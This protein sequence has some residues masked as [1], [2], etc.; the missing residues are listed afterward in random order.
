MNWVVQNGLHGLRTWSRVVSLP[1]WETI[2]T[3][4]TS[5]V[6]D[7]IRSDEPWGRWIV[8][9]QESGDTRR[10]YGRGHWPVPY[11]RHDAVTLGGLGNCRDC[12]Q[13]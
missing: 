8:G 7:A 3:I 2:S 11:G 6:P 5:L 9:S 1:A 13:F 4:T 12:R 10:A